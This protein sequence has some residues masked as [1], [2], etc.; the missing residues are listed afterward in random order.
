MDEDEDWDMEGKWEGEDDPVETDDWEELGEIERVRGIC[1]SE[2][3]WAE[4]EEEA[5][6]L[7]KMRLP[8][9]MEW[10]ILGWERDWGWRIELERVWIWEWEGETGSLDGIEKVWV[11]LGGWE[12]E[13][14]GSW[15]RWG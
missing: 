5:A 11:T 14:E 12:R 7:C 4:V 3:L 1:R 9:G 10:K 15:W 2:W 8:S 13:T 6:E